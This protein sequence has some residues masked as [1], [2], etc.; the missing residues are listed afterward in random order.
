MEKKFVIKGERNINTYAYLMMS[1]RHSYEYATKCKEGQ[2]Y[3]LMS[4]LIFSVFT[5][6]AYLNHLGCQSIKYWHAIESI[7]VWSKLKVL[8][9]HCNL[10]FDSSKRPLQT[11]SEL[12]KFRNLM[13]H[14]KS[15]TISGKEIIDE[16]IIN[17]YPDFIVT[18][19]E[20]MCTKKVTKRAIDDVKNI[21]NTLDSNDPDPDLWFLGDGNSVIS[22]YN[23]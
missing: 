12:I 4:S 5:L 3:Q 13:A 17:S 1:A 10:N 20:L 16:Q 15:E 7:K 19:W 22:K 8:Y 9:T 21:I 23:P 11:I 2:F 14:G 18:K 6:E